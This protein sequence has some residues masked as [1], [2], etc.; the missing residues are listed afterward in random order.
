MRVTEN[1]NHSLLQLYCYDVM[2]LINNM[3]TEMTTTT[4]LIISNKQQF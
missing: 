3:W 1:Y 4:T 2:P